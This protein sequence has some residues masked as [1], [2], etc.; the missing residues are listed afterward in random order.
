VIEWIPAS[1]VELAEVGGLKIFPGNAAEVTT[2]K[3]SA[4]VSLLVL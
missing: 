2:S 4:L 1:D 3:I